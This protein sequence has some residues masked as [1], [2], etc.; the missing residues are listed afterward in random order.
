M[1][2]K[3]AVKR[4]MK[5]HLS[6]VNPLAVCCAMAV[7]LAVGY[8]IWGYLDYFIPVDFGCSGDPACIAEITAERWADFLVVNIGM[9][10][11][12]IMSFG[13]LLP[14]LGVF[15]AIRDRW[16]WRT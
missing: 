3:G 10:F 6:R 16:G 13:A 9:L 4:S 2:G 8:G 12:F 1:I 5:V 15:V 7:M 14:G 11:I